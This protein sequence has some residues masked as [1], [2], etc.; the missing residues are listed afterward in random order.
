MKVK[1][2]N[3]DQFIYIAE[4]GNSEIIGYV[5]AMFLRCRNHFAYRDFDYFYIDDLCVDEKHRRQ[6][7]GKVLFEKCREQAKKLNCHH[8]DLG[9]YEFN[10]EAAAFYESCGMK[11]K[12]R[13]MEFIL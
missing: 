11:T 4:D 9:V 8:M 13:K 12:L 2:K 6:G 10:S 7:V 5:F 3:P 1:L